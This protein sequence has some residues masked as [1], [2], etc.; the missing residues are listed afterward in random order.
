MRYCREEIER[1]K[2]AIFELLKESP[3][4]TTSQVYDRLPREFKDLHC[5]NIRSHLNTLVSQGELKAKKI[6]SKM[7]VYYLPSR[8][9][10]KANDFV[11]GRVN[12]AA[13]VGAYSR[14]SKYNDYYGE[15][16]R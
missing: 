16:P 15:D 6:K 3:Y 1:R 11:L 8:P 2:E 5:N 4:L 9:D 7:K 10:P 14:A 12:Y 13:T